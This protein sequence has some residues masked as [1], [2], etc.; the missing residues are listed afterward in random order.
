MVEVLCKN[1]KTALYVHIV[2][3]CPGI[4]WSALNLKADNSRAAEIAVVES[5]KPICSR[6]SG[7]EGETF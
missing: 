4:V 5:D 7:V 1:L 3:C 6:S 2:D